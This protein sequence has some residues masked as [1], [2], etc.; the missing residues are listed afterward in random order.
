MTNVNTTSAKI[1][2]FLSSKEI[3]IAG[4]S[5]NKMK[6]GYKVFDHLRKNGYKLHIIHPEAK[7][8]DGVQCYK[9]ASELPAN[10]KN[11]YVVTNASNTDKLMESAVERGFDMIW[12]QQ[13]SDTN[14]SIKIAEEKGIEIISGKCIFMYLNPTGGHNVH[15]FFMKIFGKL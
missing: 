11:L 1:E 2:K 8:I 7:E 9:S 6:F 13:K 5:R 14:N 15:R 10:I 3:A 12:M 4:A